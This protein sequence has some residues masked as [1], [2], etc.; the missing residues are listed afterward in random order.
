MPKGSNDSWAQKLYNTLLKQKAH[1]EKPRMSNKAFII[2]HFADKV[3]T[4]IMIELLVRV[5][6][7]YHV[8]V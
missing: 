8:V 6:S 2:L 4:N 7:L 3:N 1:F 5:L